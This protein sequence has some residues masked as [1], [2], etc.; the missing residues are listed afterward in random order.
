MHK[1]SNSEKSVEQIV[2]YTINIIIAF[3]VVIKLWRWPIYTLQIN[4]KITRKF[5]VIKRQHFEDLFGSLYNDV[6]TVV[7]S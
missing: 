7:S 5:T 3:G 6:I 2:K 1:I 4:I